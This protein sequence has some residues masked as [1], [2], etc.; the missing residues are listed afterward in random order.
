M[1]CAASLAVEL[2]AHYTIKSNDEVLVIWTL[3]FE[4]II[5]NVF[6]SAGGVYCVQYHLTTMALCES[7]QLMLGFIVDTMN[8]G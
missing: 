4:I 1:V 3:I 5:N 2:L 6:E 7:N 8:K